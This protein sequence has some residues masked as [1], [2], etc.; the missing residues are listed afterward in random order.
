M[1]ARV[2]LCV[3]VYDLKPVYVCV[4]CVYPCMSVC[5]C[6]CVN[7]FSRSLCVYMLCVPEY[8]AYMS[9]THDDYTILLIDCHKG[10][11]DNY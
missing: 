4:V 1:H 3:C 11:T 8:H 6:V 7:I 10:V 9:N 5:V 2:S